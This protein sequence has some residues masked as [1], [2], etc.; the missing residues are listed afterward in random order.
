MDPDTIQW[1]P[2]NH[3]FAIIG[4]RINLDTDSFNN[5]GFRP[6]YNLQY[7]SLSALWGYGQHEGLSFYFF[8]NPIKL[9]Q[10]DYEFGYFFLVNYLYLW[11]VNY[12]FKCTLFYLM[13][14][15]S[16]YPLQ[17][18]RIIYKW[19]K[20]FSYILRILNK[21]YILEFSIVKILQCIK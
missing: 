11:N 18:E 15:H 6:T 19:K 8:G 5:H 4:F 3:P 1:I 20:L 12:W 7:A 10:L 13:F 14:G 2:G 16:W 17:L 9:V 21:S